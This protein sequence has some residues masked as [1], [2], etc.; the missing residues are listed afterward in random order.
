MHHSISKICKRSLNKIELVE[1]FKEA[2]SYSDEMLSEKSS[3]IIQLI[4]DHHRGKG[5]SDT[6]DDQQLLHQNVE[7]APLMDPVKE[8]QFF[9]QY[10]KKSANELFEYLFLLKGIVNRKM[11]TSFFFGKNKLFSFL[12]LSKRNYKLLLWKLVK[13]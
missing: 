3:A 10:V 11:L 1:H 12:Q 13:G 5:W 6:L 9:Q 8:M 2:L 4:A 7:E